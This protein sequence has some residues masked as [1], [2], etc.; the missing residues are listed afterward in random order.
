MPPLGSLSPPLAVHVER[1]M[2][3]PTKLHIAVLPPLGPNPERNPDWAVYDSEVPWPSL[4]SAAPGCR[5]PRIGRDGRPPTLIRDGPRE[6]NRRENSLTH[7]HTACH[8][9][10]HHTTIQSVPAKKYEHLPRQQ[11]QRIIVHSDSVPIERLY[12]HAR[13]HICT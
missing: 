7:T 11:Q 1:A 13:T 8:M 9:N 3:P 6:R 2:P 5:Q 12:S 4:H 10:T